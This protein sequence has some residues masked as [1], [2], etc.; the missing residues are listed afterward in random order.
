MPYIMEKSER[1][2]ILMMIIAATNALS[3]TIAYRQIK[4]EI[5]IS[6]TSNVLRRLDQTMENNLV[7]FFL[8]SPDISING[9]ARKTH[10]K[11]VNENCREE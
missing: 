6:S 5:D 4:A 10:L 1:E 3:A 8:G 9:G 11:R 7:E 2:S